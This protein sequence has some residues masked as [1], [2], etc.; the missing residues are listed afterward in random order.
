MIERLIDILIL[1]RKRK[2][3]NKSVIGGLTTFLNN[4]LSNLELYG[5]DI[6]KLKK[7]IKEYEE[8]NIEKR[9]KIFWE[10]FNEILDGLFKRREFDLEK[11]PGIG[12]K[13]KEILLKIGVKNS[14]DLIYYFPR[15]Y[16]DFG[17]LTKIINVK[18]GEYAQIQGEVLSVEKKNIRHN[19]SILK[20]KFFD[21]TSSLF[22]IWFN[23]PYL[24]KFFR[25][26]KRFLIMGEVS[27]NF[28]EWQ[29]ENPDFEEIESFKDELKEKIVPIYSQ[30]KGITSKIISNHI[31]EALKL[32]EKF[33]FDPLPREIIKKRDLVPLNFA[34]KNIH[35]PESKE[36]LK[37]SEFR[38]KYE[39]LFLFQLFLQIRKMKIKEKMGLKYDI[40]DEYRERFIKTL[41][42]TLTNGQLKVMNEIEEDLKSGKIMNRLLHGE[43]GSGKTVVAAYALYLSTLNKTQGTMMSPTEILAI[44]TYN[45]VKKFLSPFGIKVEILTGS[46][47]NKNEIKSRLKEGEIDIIIGT[48]ALIEED[49]EFKNL[50]LVIVDEQH[51]FGVLQ[52]G[53]LVKKGNYPHTLVLSATPIPR[54]LAL[55]IYGDLDIS[56]IDELPPGRRPVK[57]IVFPRE[58]K[59]KAYEFVRERLR[60]GEKIYVV[61]PLIEESEKMEI[62]SVKEKYEDFKEIFK[63]VK[64][65][66]LHGRMKG[67]EKEE[68][69]KNF[70][71]GDTQILIS[72]SVI[73]V[74]IDVPEANVILVEDAQ[75]FG[76]LTLHQLRGRVGR[77]DKESYCLLILSNYD[78]DSLRRVR[79]LEKTNSGLEI[80]EWDLKFRGTGEL[81]GERQ[82]GVS[83]FKIVNL[84][85]EDDF[86]ILKVA[87][88]DAEYFI[89]NNSILDYPYLIKELSLRFKDFKLLDIS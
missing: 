24:E 20:V 26:G 61:C 75:R 12:E 16:I 27:Y 89:K 35:F 8:E 39:E 4:N 76:L 44:Q 19:L 25:K 59:E 80:S 28:G 60:D 57:T 67:D 13:R 7:L 64:I 81:G 42:F 15:K 17:K 51:R 85:S 31:N 36:N 38:L 10:I 74:G 62:A 1:E 84:L 77:G 46:T 63:G 50:S 54:T 71:E 23:Q 68:K 2:F 86:E 69:I 82:H 79:V 73:E 65:D 9:K 47:K 3:D 49:T 83:D 34:L 43:V 5:I 22:G 33:I 37:K 48:H 72:T 41:P 6:K 88:E 87:R 66:I 52:R 21:G 70:R 18:N 45:N 53:A 14:Y 29:M 56:T 55:S 30:T 11:I 78:K 40:K 32:T 58:E